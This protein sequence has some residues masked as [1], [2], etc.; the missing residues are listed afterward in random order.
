MAV[1]AFGRVFELRNPG[2]TIFEQSLKAVKEE[3]MRDFKW[4]RDEAL[5]AM[6]WQDD[7]GQTDLARCIEKVAKDILRKLGLPTEANLDVGELPADPVNLFE[8]IWDEA[9]DLVLSGSLAGSP[10]CARRILHLARAV[11]Q[12]L[13]EQWRQTP[14]ANPLQRV[15]PPGRRIFPLNMLNPEPSSNSEASV[16]FTEM[17]QQNS[18]RISGEAVGTWTA[19]SA[20]YEVCSAGKTELDAVEEETTEG[21]AF[22]RP[23]LPDRGAFVKEI[24]GAAE[25]GEGL[26]PACRRVLHSEPFTTSHEG[27][28]CERCSNVILP[29]PHRL[30]PQ[31]YSC[32]DCR[33]SIC[34]DCRLPQEE[35]RRMIDAIRFRHRGFI[36]NPN[37]LGI[38]G[39]RFHLAAREGDVQKLKALLKPE[40][41]STDINSQDFSQRTPLHDLVSSQRCTLEA[42]EFMLHHKANV[43]A[44][45]DFDQTPLHL[46]AEMEHKEVVDF[47]TWS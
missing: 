35:Q 28:T 46:A 23:E 29:I 17:T 43:A 36:A 9:R 22:L 26:C 12:R 30:Q 38:G 10:S 16:R 3:V 2:K 31:T 40:T 1:L 13:E 7:E 11:E 5:P 44:R 27:H 41:G 21:S 15:A 39:T 6:D 37:N 34:I 47:S 19:P 18:T 4:I 14:E 32:F 45:D 42:V 8:A 20:R 33:W 25:A 24:Q